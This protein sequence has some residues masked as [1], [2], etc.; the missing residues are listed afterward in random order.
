MR[1]NDR[2]GLE[3]YFKDETFKEKTACRRHQATLS[4]LVL[5]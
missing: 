2:E 1:A 4:H 3:N 5:K